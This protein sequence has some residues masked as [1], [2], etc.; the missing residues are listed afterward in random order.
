MVSFGLQIAEG[1]EFINRQGFVHRDLAL[2]NVLVESDYHVR[3]ADLGL[4]RVSAGTDR[5]RKYWSLIGW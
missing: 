2:R 3:I 5:T 4:T 1:M